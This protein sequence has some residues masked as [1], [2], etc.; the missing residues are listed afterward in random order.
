MH[1]YGIDL[2]L[3]TYDEAGE[4][5]NGEIRLQVKATEAIKTRSRRPVIPWRLEQRDVRFWLNE[6]M[7]V[8]LVVYDE[9]EQKAY[10]LHVQAHFASRSQWRFGRTVTVDIPTNQVLSQSAVRTF[11]EFRQQILAQIQ[12]VDDEN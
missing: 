3:Y 5:E 9:R 2:L 1:D 10:W 11:R 4:V 8:I 12:G 6:L 7:P